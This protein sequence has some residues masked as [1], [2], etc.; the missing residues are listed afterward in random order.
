MSQTHE[1]TRVLKEI[2]PETERLIRL[3]EKVGFGEV[4]IVIQNG[5]PVRAENIVRQVKLDSPDEFEQGFKT[6]SL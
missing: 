6:I 3:I 2:S 1:K 4:R 5:K